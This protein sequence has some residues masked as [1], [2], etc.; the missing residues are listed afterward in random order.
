MF[1]LARSKSDQRVVQN[2]RVACP[3]RGGDV[4]I[5]V[6]ATCEWLRGID[7]DGGFRF[8]R[9]RIDVLRS[10]PGYPPC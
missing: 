1:G 6:C 10:L 9:C 7:D 4:D 8:A 2:G 5:D 3:N